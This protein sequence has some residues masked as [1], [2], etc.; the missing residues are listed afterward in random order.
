MRGSRT[1]NVLYIIRLLSFR[2]LVTPVLGEGRHRTLSGEAPVSAQR[3]SQQGIMT[4]PVRRCD[5]DAEPLPCPGQAAARI[6]PV[7]W[8]GQAAARIDHPGRD[9]SRG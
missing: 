9:H 8:L 4:E 7:P 1:L 6:E 2:I 5:R 3:Q